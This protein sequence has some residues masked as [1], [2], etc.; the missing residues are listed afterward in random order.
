[1]KAS[2]LHMTRADLAHEGAPALHDEPHPPRQARRRS[3]APALILHTKLD[4]ATWG[5][6]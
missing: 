6:E 2:A 5:S 4:N 3:K 1:M